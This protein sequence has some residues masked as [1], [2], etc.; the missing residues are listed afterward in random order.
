MPGCAY[1]DIFVSVWDAF[2]SGDL[3]TA[4]RTL[5]RAL[6]LLLHASQTFSLFVGTQKEMLRRAGVIGSARLRAPAEPVT[7]E[8]YEEFAALL[9]EAR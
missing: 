5:H 3:A 2:T 7:D 9:E 8:M 1:A 4:R 6:P